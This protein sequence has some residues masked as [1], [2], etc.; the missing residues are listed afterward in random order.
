MKRIRAEVAEF[1]RRVEANEP[2]PVDFA[3]DGA[4]IAGLFADDDGATIDLSGSARIAEIVAQRELLKAREADGAEAAKA[5]KP[6]DAEIIYLLGNATRGRLADGR[7]IEA[8]TIRRGAYEVKP[9]SYRT[10]RIK[11]S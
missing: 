7:L 11:R 5:R 3:R 9:S 2:Y 6:I 10:V 4:I 8:K 1:W